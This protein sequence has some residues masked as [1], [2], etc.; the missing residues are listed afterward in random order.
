[1]DKCT[2]VVL[3]VV[4]LMPICSFAKSFD[5]IRSERCLAVEQEVIDLYASKEALGKQAMSP[6][7]QAATKEY[8]EARKARDLAADFQGSI[9]DKRERIA[10][11][12]KKLDQSEAKWREVA[13]AEDPKK[14]LEKI[15][16]VLIRHGAMCR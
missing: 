15:D 7:V 16:N 14:Y 1:M 2:K 12:Q 3:T 11:A 10:E 5:E 9:I 6:V 4:A 8:M 13:I